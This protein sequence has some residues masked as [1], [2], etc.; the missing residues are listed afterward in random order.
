MKAFLIVVGCTAILAFI[1]VAFG[2]EHS[3][4]RPRRNVPACTVIWFDGTCIRR[5]IAYSDSARE[6][7]DLLWEALLMRHDA[8]KMV[9]DNDRIDSMKKENLFVEVVYAE[10]RTGQFSQM[11]IAKVR[12][13]RVFVPLLPGW[14]RGSIALYYGSPGYVTGQ[15]VITRIDPEVMKQLLSALPVS[16]NQTAH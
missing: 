7:G 4:I 3:P 1:V 2:T 13:D 8:F 16:E 9:V 10:F 5:C 15:A 11:P 14:D 6:L 12:A